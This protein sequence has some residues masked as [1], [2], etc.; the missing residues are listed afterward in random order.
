MLKV[1]DKVR[2]I[3]YQDKND[4]WEYTM[5]GAK[6]GEVYEIDSVDSYSSVCIYTG[7]HFVYTSSS[8]LRLVGGLNDLL[9]D[10]NLARLSIALGKHRSYLNKMIQQGVSDKTYNKIKDKLTIDWNSDKP[11]YVNDRKHV[12]FTIK[13]IS[14]KQQKHKDWLQSLMMSGCVKL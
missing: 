1:G 2:L 13:P 8:C 3:K 5:W 6:I 9:K 7:E 12:P 11:L 10:A 4:P 14:C